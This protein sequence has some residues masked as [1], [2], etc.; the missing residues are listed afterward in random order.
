M[1]NLSLHSNTLFK[2]DR[3]RGHKILTEKHIV[4]QY[5]V[6]QKIRLETWNFIFCIRKNW[7]HCQFEKQLRNS[8]LILWVSLCVKWFHFGSTWS[9]LNSLTGIGWNN[10]N[11][12]GQILCN[13][14][15]L[16]K[17][18]NKIHKKCPTQTYFSNKFLPVEINMQIQGMRI[19]IYL[20]VRIN[21]SV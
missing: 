6:V 2:L 19:R 21:I 1:N 4:V 14:F 10:W 12:Q 7:W 3:K 11:R 17:T 13:A 9:T 5:I 20:L 18:K 16:I 8:I 15:L